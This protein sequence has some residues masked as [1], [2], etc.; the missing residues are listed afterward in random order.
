MTTISCG[1]SIIETIGDE[2]TVGSLSPNFQV[3][4]GDFKRFILNEDFKDKPLVI[5]TIPSLDTMTCMLCL[6]HF[7]RLAKEK[8]YN[9][10]VV[11]S[12]T[13]FA[14]KRLTADLPFSPEFICTDMVL[15]ELGI[16]YNLLIKS[17]PLASFIARAVF[18]LTKE[19]KIH[20]AELSGDITAPIDYEKLEKATAE[21]FDD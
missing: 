19:H 21:V 2:P 18:V 11:S 3:C 1:E 13:P 20:Y 7:S 14:L 10:L 15:R 12:D 4:N 9:Y 5:F 6:K 16:A 17:G 8:K